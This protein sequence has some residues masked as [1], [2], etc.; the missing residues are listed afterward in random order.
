MPWALGSVAA[1]ALLAGLILGSVRERS[2]SIA[3]G[4]VLQMAGIA[5]AT[6]VW[7]WVQ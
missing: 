3:A 2:L 4:L 6:F 7:L 1:A 5:A